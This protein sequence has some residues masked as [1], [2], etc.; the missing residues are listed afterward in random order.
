MSKDNILSI[1]SYR[2]YLAGYVDPQSDYSSVFLRYIL[3]NFSLAT[4][5]I[6]N[7]KPNF[8]IISQT[9]IADQFTVT[10]L[11]LLILEMTF[12]YL[13]QLLPIKSLTYVTFKCIDIDHRILIFRLIFIARTSRNSI[14]Q[15]IKCSQL[16]RKSNLITF[17]M[18]V[19]F[20]LIN[21]IG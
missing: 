11:S 14:K 16:C 6:I 4:N 12:I 10:S 2:S 17:S 1:C 3:F 9:Q 13:I 5:I 7:R 20:I 18:P 21:Y 15:R 8:N 19:G